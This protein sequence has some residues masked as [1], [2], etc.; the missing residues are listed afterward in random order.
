MYEL[1]EI[2]VVEQV[3]SANNFVTRDEFEAVIGQIK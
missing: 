2:P 1:K 3:P